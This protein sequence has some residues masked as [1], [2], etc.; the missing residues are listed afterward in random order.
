MAKVAA[1]A[2]FLVLAL[3]RVGNVM[4]LLY[5][6]AKSGSAPAY[7]VMLLLT[8]VYAYITKRAVL[9]VYNFDCKKYFESRNARWK[10]MGAVAKDVPRLE[11][12]RVE[13]CCQ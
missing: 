1:A 2:P 4:L 10:K 11:E 12:E 5:M 8:A 9:F 6:G 3:A 13:S 7:G